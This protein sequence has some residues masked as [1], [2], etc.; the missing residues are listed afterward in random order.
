MNKIYKKIYYL[1]I[2]AVIVISACNI[3]VNAA[4]GQTDYVIDSNGKAS[5]PMCYI[6]E[7]RIERVYEGSYL[8]TPQ[9]MYIDRDD[10]LYVADSANNRIVKFNAELEYVSQFTAGNSL[11][12]PSGAYFDYEKKE[13]YIADTDNGRIVV[14]DEKDKFVREYH[15]PESELLDDDL[16][17]N[18]T[19]ISLGI[20]GHI[21]LLK[22]QNFMQISQEGEFKGYVGSTKLPANII[23]AIVRRFASEKQK[24]MLVKEQPS[25]YINFTMDSK[26]VIYAVAGTE[27]A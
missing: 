25:P 7:K 22:G 8:D 27:S 18:P 1:F 2:C 13:L 23:M 6:P 19:N 14:V 21:Y 24:K 17:F 12:K 16:T 15:K 11:N 9:N 3:P 5:L 26:G 20:Q 4:I 10:N